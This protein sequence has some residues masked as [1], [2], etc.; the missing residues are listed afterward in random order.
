MEKL[1]SRC[2]SRS[3]QS[4]ISSTMIRQCGISEDPLRSRRPGG[5]GLAGALLLL[6]AGC[7]TGPA[8]SPHG[9]ELARLSNLG[10]AHL[11]NR[12]AAQAVEAFSTATRLAPGCAPCWRNLARARL[13]AGEPRPALEALGRA[14]KIESRSPATAYL[15]GLAHAH[16]DQTEP[17]VAAF[18]EAVELDPDAAPLRYQLAVAYQAAGRGEK[19]REQLR[20][21]IRLDPRHA[22]AYYRLARFANADGR[23]QDY[24]RWNGEFLRLRAA[25]GDAGRSPAALEISAYTPA[26]P[27]EAAGTAQPSAPA[28]PLAVRFVDA[29]A[30]GLSGLADKPVAAIDVLDADPDKSYT[31]VA[32]APDGALTLL[33]WRG[34]AFAELPLQGVDGSSPFPIRRCLAAD[35]HDDA[36]P[37]EVFDPASQALTDLLLLG[38]EGARLWRRT[39]PRS[40][41]DAT[42][43]AGLSGLRGETALW[44]DVDHDGDLD[45]VVGTESGLDLWQNTGDGTYLRSADGPPGFAVE[46]PVRSL[47]AT[48]LEGDVGLDL[49]VARRGEPTAV[50][51]SVQGGSFTRRPAPPAPWPE[52]RKVLLDDLDDDGSVD[53]VLVG[54]SSVEIRSARGGGRR[55]LDLGGLEPAAAALSDVDNDGWLDLWVGGRDEAGRGRLRLWRGVGSAG[56]AGDGSDDGDAL[57]LGALDLP[58]VLDLQ[59]ADFD[60]DGDS[61]LV[62]ATEGGLRFLR[63]DGGNVNHQL[64]LRLVGTKSNVD[65]LGTDVEL[66]RGSFRVHR[67]VSDRPLEIGVGPRDRLDTL[68]TVW[69]NGVVDNRIDVP[70]V[71]TTVVEKNVATGSCPFL[72]AWDG[73]RMRFVTDLL[74]N[75]PLGLPLRRGD[76][77]PADPTELV[78]IG[79]EERLAPRGGAYRLQVT[80]EF[81]EVAYLDQLEL[82]AVDHPP[83]VEAQPTD[84]LMP[85]PFPPSEVWLLG[86]RRPLRAALRDGRRDRRDLTAALREVDGRFAPAGTPLPP[87]LRGITYPT[88]LVLDFG[89]LDPGRPWVLALTGWLQYGDASTNI[90]LSQNR[91]VQV[92][93]PRLEAEVAPGRWR[94]LPV[95]VGMPAGKTKTLLT[96]LSGVLPP[97]TRRLR[98][99]TTYEIRWDR[100]ALFERVHPRAAARH[101]L[102][103]ARARL[104]FFGFSE[105][106]ARGTDQPTTPDHR[107]VAPRPP[108]RTTLEGWCTRYG[109]V[110][111]LV[112]ARDGRLALVDS[113]DA[114]DLAFPAGGLPPVP[115]GLVRTFFLRAVGWDKD[116]DPNVAGGDRVGPLPV[117]APGPWQTRY[118]TRWVPRDLFAPRRSER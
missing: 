34:G 109:P 52:A 46:G 7:G 103:A 27:M 65:G 89:P 92:I 113:G 37:G 95:T 87:P 18:E 2:A 22:A 101:R 30:T 63:N 53:A 32:V 14:A 76:D 74:G 67:V 59:A 115:P 51:W 117:A 100:A 111:D 78:R 15:E 57:G 3:A 88:R 38:P 47:A 44:A 12:Q 43:E 21:T 80:S 82:V 75:S 90:A 83:A 81:R 35:D 84:K 62:V 39:G 94:P 26:E 19:A 77:L 118:S 64:K 69:T 24:E 73:R 105:L 108:W 5:R 31:L 10:R 54:R 11:E 102:A 23:T 114:L 16:L 17:A 33:E 98:L 36:P 72:Y 40:F 6:L 8:A 112:A 93:A 45:L 1:R 20:E 106:A 29:T 107:V 56:R 48:D 25:G 91:S 66:A 96:D 97:G 70:V 28:P 104:S 49:V 85:P 42:A 71:P 13:Q 50:L 79:G 58:P 55:S 99:T 68:R 4:K 61:D 116:G 110:G 60:G 9:A 86:H 41:H